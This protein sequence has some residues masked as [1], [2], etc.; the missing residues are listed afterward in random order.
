MGTDFLSARG[1]LLDGRLDATL[2]L[3]DARRPRGELGATQRRRLGKQLDL[4]TMITVRRNA[5]SAQ[6]KSTLQIKK[7]NRLAVLFT[8]KFERWC[9]QRTVLQIG[10]RHD[11]MLHRA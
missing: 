11:V 7:F 1:A 9:K 3:L 8:Q 6:S 2:P 10:E 5:R 4:C